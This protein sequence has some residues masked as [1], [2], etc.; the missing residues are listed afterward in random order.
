LLAAQAVATQAV[1]EHANV[2]A[3]VVGQ[4]AQFPPQAR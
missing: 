4:T 2:V 1:P 3:P